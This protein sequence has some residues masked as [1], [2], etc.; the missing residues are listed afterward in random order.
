MISFNLLLHNLYIVMEDLN[1]SKEWRKEGVGVIV[2]K[3]GE[4]LWVDV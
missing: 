2:G 1:I 3:I 4:V